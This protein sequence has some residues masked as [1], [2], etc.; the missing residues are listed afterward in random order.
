MGKLIFV[1]ND[2][3]PLNSPYMDRL[4]KHFWQMKE[5]YHDARRSIEAKWRQCDEAYLC[6]RILPD[7]GA[8]DFIDDSEFGET[9]AMDNSDLVVI[10]ML[11]AILPPNMPY[12]NP[13]SADE[14]EPVEVAENVRD[15]LIW[16]H[17]Q[18]RTRRQLAKWLKMMCVRGDGAFYWEHETEIVK[19]PVVG[20]RERQAIED[21]LKTGRITDVN[22]RVLEEICTFNGPVIRVIDTYDY[23]LSPISD[24]TNKRREPFVIQTYRHLA[25]LH[26]EVDDKND[27]VYGNL[28]DLDGTYAREL[29]SSGADGGARV[30]SLQI[31]GVEPEADRGA[32]KLVP[33]YIVYVPYIKFE[34]KEFY[35]TY[36]HFALNSTG[37]S[38]RSQP[39]MIRVETNPTGQRQF[40]FDNYN[41]FFTNAPYGISGIEKSLTALR[42]KNVLGA[43]MFNAAVASEFPAVNAIGDAFKD[44]E[45]SFMPG[46]INE[47]TGMSDPSKVIAPM[48]VP[49]KGLQLAWND[50]KFWG[51]E[52]RTKMKIDGLQA[53]APTRTSKKGQKTA[54]QVNHDAS[55]GNLFLDEMSTKYS[56]TL[57][58]F[59]QGS[60]DVMKD[61][62]EPNERGELEY[63][64]S[65]HNR[66]TNSYL[67]VHDFAR[68]RSITIGFMQGI[69]DKGQRLQHIQQ[70][71]GMVAQA[72]QAGAMPNAAAIINDLTMEC[73]R[74]LDVPLKP[75]AMMTPEQLAS[76][77]PRV[78]V[79][80][81][82]QALQQIGSAGGGGMPPS[83]GQG[84]GESL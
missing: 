30:R 32:T 67:S 28:K 83:L 56:D 26:A 3:P 34:D 38:L 18:S 73:A 81:I 6:Y 11:Q 45:I 2:V 53:E 7:T 44:G 33:V 20:P 61:K 12:L 50:M 29:W 59:F 43:L 74:L 71:M 69:F 9:D 51:D 58:E 75:Q 63:Q 46:A 35:D 10:R 52:L 82:Q 13:S 62:I 48:P 22:T 31:M 1:P 24:L 76:Q 14:N 47:L 5:Y 64:R 21:A 39:R 27:K 80:A 60:F 70:F 42:Q 8:I 79:M 57:T 4:A 23:F 84:G 68:P 25:E 54:T 72:A 16:K 36:F 78:Q 37:K 65:L 15:F 77:D 66:L 17:R 49:D 19:R 41:E 55:S 40:L